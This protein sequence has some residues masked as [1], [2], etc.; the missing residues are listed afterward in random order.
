MM[1]VIH[2]CLFMGKCVHSFGTDSYGCIYIIVESA[3][4]TDDGTSIDNV[5]G[6]MAVELVKLTTTLV[7]VAK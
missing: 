7:T 2:V 6:L 3:Y 4:R 5:W 1:I